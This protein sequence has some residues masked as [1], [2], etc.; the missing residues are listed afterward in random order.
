MLALDRYPDCVIDRTAVE[1]SVLWATVASGVKAMKLAMP[2]FN[3][4]TTAEGG[5]LVT[6]AADVPDVGLVQATKA[7]GIEAIGVSGGLG[8]I[9]IFLLRRTGLRTGLTH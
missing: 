7:L 9:A 5:G 8:G 1:T 3:V 2:M 6:E 4:T